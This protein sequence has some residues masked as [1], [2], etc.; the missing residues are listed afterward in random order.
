MY[1]SCAT[2]NKDAVRA[3]LD[4]LDVIRRFIE[5]Y[6]DTFTFVLTA[7]GKKVHTH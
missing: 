4:Q 2:N 6:S 5:Q 7:Q 3:G 1:V